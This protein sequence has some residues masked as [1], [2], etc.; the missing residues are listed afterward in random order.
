[1]ACA[2]VETLS[3]LS[4]SANFHNGSRKMNHNV[5]YETYSPCSWA[6]HPEISYKVT[7]NRGIHVGISAEV[8]C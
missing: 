4:T 7:V 8:K 1:M 5:A 2:N 3:V 6:C